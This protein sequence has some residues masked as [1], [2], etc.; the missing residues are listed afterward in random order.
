MTSVAG[1]ANYFRVEGGNRLQGEFR[2]QGAKNA[3][4]K[5]MA[6]TIL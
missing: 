2:V 1:Q 5:Q 3:V 6:A 4:L